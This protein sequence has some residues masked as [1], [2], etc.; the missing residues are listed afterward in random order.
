MKVERRHKEPDR[1]EMI[2][3]RVCVCVCVVGTCFYIEWS[4]FSES[5]TFSR[6]AAELLVCFV[7]AFMC[8]GAPHSLPFV[9]STHKHGPIHEGLCYLKEGNTRNEL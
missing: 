8:V 5:P 3:S 4:F 2:G 1:L 6:D 9:F 7:H